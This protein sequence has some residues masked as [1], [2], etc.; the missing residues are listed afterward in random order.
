[1]KE[2]II[3]KEWKSPA[4]KKYY[5][6][7]KE[8]IL[9]GQKKSKNNYYH[10]NK[11]KLIADKK[12]Y[13]ANN[14]EKVKKWRKT[15]Y[16]KHREEILLKARLK[17]GEPLIKKCSWCRDILSGSKTKFCSSRCHDQHKVYKKR[18]GPIWMWRL[19]SKYKIY[20]IF[21]QYIPKI[22]SLFVKKIPK[23]FIKIFLKSK[24]KLQKLKT[25]LRYFKYKA[26]KAK[27]CGH[28]RV[29]RHHE[30]TEYKYTKN[31]CSD[32]CKQI[33]E[34][35]IV[36]AKKQRN[37]AAWGT[38][39]QPDAETK[40]RIIAEKR[41]AWEDNKKKTDPAFKLLK[42]MRVRTRKVLKGIYKEGKNWNGK[43]L[44][45]FEK[46]GIKSGQELR[47]HIE[48]Q[49]QEGMNWNNYG[50]GKGFWVVDH[51]TPIAY[52][53]N[54]FDLL[55]DLEIQKKCFGKENLKPMWWVDNA[56]KA[57][58]LNYESK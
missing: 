11:E 31:F 51:D 16:N 32:K 44:S 13:K 43:K 14:P 58:K 25:H 24:K 45:I 50:S 39:H 49:W 4:Q 36:E 6:K 8:K 34:N 30:A 38:E 15:W 41:R 57:A 33:H 55:N 18:M 12:I 52:Y 3:E 9:A 28:W 1:M 19:Y 53:K 10:R 17:K 21:Y 46:L 26:Y 56:H 40:K 48:A 2:N 20:K 7:N 35:K 37:L 29:Y 54:N 42:R 47:D 27:V 5:L 22:K 23:F